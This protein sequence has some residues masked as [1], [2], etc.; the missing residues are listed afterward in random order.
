M[1]SEGSV[2]GHMT[3]YRL[4]GSSSRNLWYE[5]FFTSQQTGSRER[6]RR[7]QGHDTTKDPI[8]MTYFLQLGLLPLNVSK[9]P[10]SWEPSVQHRSLEEAFR[11][12]T[13]SNAHTRLAS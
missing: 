7:G 12:E 13:L 4:S 3:A 10:L 5:S 2:P 6:E 9:P 8:P 1:V 11:T